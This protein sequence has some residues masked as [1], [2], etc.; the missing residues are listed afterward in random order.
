[1]TDRSQRPLRQPGLDRP[2]D[3]GVHR[4]PHDTSPGAPPAGAPASGD[5]DDV[6][7]DAEWRKIEAERIAEERDEAREDVLDPPPAPRGWAWWALAAALVAGGLLALAINFPGLLTSD[8][9]QQ[10]AGDRP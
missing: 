10:P 4:P 3:P 5:P 1:M 8:R 7:V 6:A 2:G 9:P